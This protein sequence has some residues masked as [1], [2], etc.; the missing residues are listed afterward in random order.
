MKE[1]K[2]GK[3]NVY[4]TIELKKKSNAFPEFEIRFPHYV[5]R[6]YEQERILKLHSCCFYFYVSHRECQETICF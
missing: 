4:K 2:G 1:T 5:S 3:E 6:N